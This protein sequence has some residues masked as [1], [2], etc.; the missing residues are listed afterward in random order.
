MSSLGDYI[1]PGQMLT[2]AEIVARVKA[3]PKLSNTSKMPGK[4]W[5]LPAWETCP[6]A[7][8]EFDGEPVAACSRCYALTG[9]YNYPATIA[10]REHNLDDWQKDGWVY[11]MVKA[12]GKAK[13]FRWFDSGDCYSPILA[14]KIWAVIVE[15]PNCQ[16]WLP[17]R[18]HKD[19][20]IFYHLERIGRL[21]NAVVRYS[22]DSRTG[23]RLDFGL[24]STIIQEEDDFIPEKGY[25]LCRSGERGGKC[26]SCRACWSPAVTTVAYIAHG[27][28]VSPKKFEKDLIS[29]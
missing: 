25:S 6:G 18:S 20:A 19:P 22:S 9:A 12:I 29:V 26:G 14:G 21:R 11:A 28:K 17:S 27:N 10:A 2:P 5:S 3:K 16:H 1:A 7:R 8:D 24:N 13:Y 23:E 15:T 4:S